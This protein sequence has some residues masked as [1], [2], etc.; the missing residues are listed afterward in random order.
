MTTYHTYDID[1]VPAPSDFE[2]APDWPGFTVTP[3]T[4]C[5]YRFWTQYRNVN[6][7]RP[8]LW[9]WIENYDGSVDGVRLR[10][11]AEWDALLARYEHERQA[12]DAADERQTQLDA[13][14]A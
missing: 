5:G 2:L 10:T 4:C 1:S 8:Y 6:H 12:A 7:V 14:R 11:V 9:T 3:D 13:L